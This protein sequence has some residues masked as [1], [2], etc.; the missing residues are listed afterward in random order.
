MAYRQDGQE[1]KLVLFNGPRHSGKDTAVLRCVETFNAYHFKLSAPNKAAIKAIFE[2]TDE[3][4][5]YLES[6]KTQDTSLLFGTSYVKAQISFSEDWLKKF[7]GIHVFGELARRKVHREAALNRR[8]GLFCCS[9]SGFACEAEPLVD[10]FGEENVL[11]V[12]LVREGKTFEGDSRS[13]IDLPGVAT[14][15]L[16]NDDKESYLQSVDD[17][18]S[19]FLAEDP[20]PF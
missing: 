6:I 19:S 18:V 14:V 1:R 15:T 3:D 13:Y 17:L 7:L 9:D 11:L 20:L 8:Q 2:L 5:D 16:L 4:V 10:L 12:K